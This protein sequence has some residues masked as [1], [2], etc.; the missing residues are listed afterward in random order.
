MQI[1]IVSPTRIEIDGK[2]AG[3]PLDVFLAREDL[4]PQI[5]EEFVTWHARHVQEDSARE[6]AADKR[7]A[8]IRAECAAQVASIEADMAVLGTKDEAKAM[9]A[10]QRREELLSELA[11]LDGKPVL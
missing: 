7:I 5:R 3:L 10:A 6:A 8:D 2:D 9:R 4:R 1:T 11:K